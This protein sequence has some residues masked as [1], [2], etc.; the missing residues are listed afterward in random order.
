MLSDSQ[1][2]QAKSLAFE[3]TQCN[4][5]I[6]AMT[7]K[8][9]RN[10]LKPESREQWQKELTSMEQHKQEIK[11]IFQK[12]LSVDLQKHQDATPLGIMSQVRKQHEQELQPIISSP[13]RPKEPVKEPPPAVWAIDSYKIELER[14]GEPKKPEKEPEQLTEQTF[15]VTH[16][17]R[18]LTVAERYQQAMERHHE[19]EHRPTRE[20]NFDK[21]PGLEK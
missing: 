10:D 7:Y 16:P 5:E 6:Q 9:N 12:E 1:I 8:L 13:D 2:K 20:F 21:D 3:Y 4:R 14:H 11:D 19:R 15:T 18:K 17:E